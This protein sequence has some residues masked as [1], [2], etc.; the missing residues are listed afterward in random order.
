MPK[1]YKGPQKLMTIGQR[2]REDRVSKRREALSDHK[3]RLAGTAVSMF[4][5]DGN[6]LGFIAPCAGK[7]SNFVIK[8]AG[9]SKFTISIAEGIALSGITGEDGKGQELGEIELVTF[10]TILCT[11]TEVD[12]E[13]GI[14][15]YVGFL[16]RPS[17]K[18]GVII[19]DADTES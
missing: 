10:D 5:P 11:V 2:L 6:N 17:G 12:S 4:S 13:K 14:R 8:S 19:P 9:P 7:A 1:N 15:T 16:F 18:E 3:E